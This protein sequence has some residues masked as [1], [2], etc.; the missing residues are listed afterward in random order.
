[1][2]AGPEDPLAFYAGEAGRPLL[3]P[4]EE[5]G[6]ARAV[7]LGREAV[8]ELARALGEEEEKV[9]WAVRE[10][11]GR[12]ELLARVRALP[13]GKRLWALAKEGEAAR[14]ELVLRNLRLAL[15]VALENRG[16]A[17]ALGVPLEDLV[18]EAV[19][20][21]VRATHTFDWR[22]GYRFSTY[23]VRWVQQAVGRAL[24]VLRAGIRP[25]FRKALAMAKAQAARRVLGEEAS[26]EELAS[27]LG[28]DWTEEEV[29][30]VLAL[31]LQTLSLDLPV[32]EDGEGLLAD[33]VPALL[34]SPEEEALRR[35]TEERLWRA[36]AALPE[37]ERRV[38]E[39]LYGLDGA[40]PLG[41]KE[42]AREFGRSHTW[43]RRREAR[44][45]A[46]LR[47]LL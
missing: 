16:R 19:R 26:L 20:G 46:R 15:K 43:V 22:K 23:A 18:A 45:L 40:P 2:E 28:G 34:P 3:S 42:A 36:L 6:L 38:L 30:E 35:V 44:A 17:E 9:L 14:D 37:E 4:H 1:V 24:V 21:L 7:A 8:R 32:G 33:F 12:A 13:E 5:T 25:S 10:E 27:L 29:A 47:E 11:R 41:Y 31:E 39:C